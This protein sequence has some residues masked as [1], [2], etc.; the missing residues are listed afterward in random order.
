A[1]LGDVVPMPQGE[2]YSGKLDAD[3]ALKGRMSSIE[4]EKYEDFNAIGTLKLM[5]MLYNSPDLP[6]AVN[7]KSMLFRFSPKNLAL[8]NLDAKMGKSDFQVN[9]TI[10]NYLGYFLRDE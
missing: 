3:I 7:V 9:G 10:D 6:D 4:K 2:S 1:T 5:D 8:E